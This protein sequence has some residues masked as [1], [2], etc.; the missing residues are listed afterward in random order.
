MQRYPLKSFAKVDIRHLISDLI[1]K[2]I[3]LLFPRAT[4]SAVELEGVVYKTTSRI[5]FNNTSANLVC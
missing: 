5:I 2:G 4:S 1:V 3:W